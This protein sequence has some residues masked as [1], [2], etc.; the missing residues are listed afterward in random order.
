MIKEIVQFVDALPPETFNRNLQLKEGMY[1]FLTFQ[2]DRLFIDENEILWVN[3]N[4][5]PDYLFFEF[6]KRY[7]LSKMITGKSMNSTEKIF[8]DIGTP[9]GISISGKGIKPDI[10]KNETLL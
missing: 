9:Y 4:T 5:E 10:K 7:N 3:K 2:G 6:L 1:M 8:I